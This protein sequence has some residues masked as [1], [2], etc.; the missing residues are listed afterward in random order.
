[1]ELKL[2]YSRYATILA[3]AACMAAG[4]GQRAYAQNKTG[5]DAYDGTWSLDIA[6]TDFGKTAPPKSQRMTLTGTPTSRKWT[7]QTVAAD[8]KSRTGT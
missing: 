5:S 3:I 2:K 7:T 8:G 1:M 4:T 6:K